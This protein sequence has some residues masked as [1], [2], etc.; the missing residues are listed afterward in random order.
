MI[1]FREGGIFLQILWGQINFPVSKV[2]GIS[3]QN[4]LIYINNQKLFNCNTTNLVSVQ[5]WGYTV[6][7]ISFSYSTSMAQSNITVQVNKPLDL[8]YFT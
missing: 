4:P 7:F 6:V 2:G 3:K 5:N 1:N 8:K